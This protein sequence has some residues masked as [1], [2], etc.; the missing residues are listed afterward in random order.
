MIKSCALALAVGLLAAAGARPAA[1]DAAR[2]CNEG[3]PAAAVMGC[4]ILIESGA[5]QHEAMVVALMNRA[6]AHAQ[7]GHRDDAKADLDKAIDLAPDDAL[8]HYNRGNI[9]FDAGS[10][11]AAI[12]DFDAAIAVESSFA[13][14]YFNRGLAFKFLGRV[15]ESMRDLKRAIELDPG[16]SSAKEELVHIEEQR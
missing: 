10:F 6:I 13:L 16:L 2:D 8:L 14:A 15:E 4:S 12:A 9:L 5:L 7:L 3:H 11:E 1:A